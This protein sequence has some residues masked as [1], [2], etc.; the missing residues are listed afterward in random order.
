MGGSLDLC[1]MQPR[2]QDFPAPSNFL[3]KSPRDVVGC[4]A[5]QFFGFV[6]IYFVFSSLERG[7]IV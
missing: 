6:L 1:V 5:F 2:P 4:R 3:E 7:V